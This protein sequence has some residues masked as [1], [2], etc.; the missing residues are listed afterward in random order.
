[1]KKSIFFLI[2]FFLV[3]PSVAKAADATI[4][5][6]SSSGVYQ[7]NKN[8]TT[9]I[10]INSGG[11]NVNAA[12]STLRF[13]PKYFNIV[14]INKDKSIFSLWTGNPKF[15][16]KTG[17]IN[18]GGGL[19]SKFHDRAG[20]ILTLTIKPIKAG[21]AKIDVGTTSQITLADGTGA[22]IY[23]PGLGSN[24][25]IGSAKDVKNANAF[26]AKNLG[27]FFLQTEVGNSLWFVNAG[28][29]R[30]YLIS[31]SSDLSTIARRIGVKTDHAL[32]VKALKSK[33]SKQSG[34]KFL[35]D[36]KDNKIYFI[37]PTTLKGQIITDFVA[38]YTS[39]VAAAKPIK[40]SDLY[41]I[42]DWAV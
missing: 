19:P 21:V 40:N 34:G 16:N 33:F 11:N 12:E 32:M 22:N 24:F 42:P 28:D 31:S 1:M 5:L 30:R 36:K 13:N 25:I 18:F 17:A 4:S 8:F 7:V 41:K 23:T 6:S 39:F 14:K 20:L 3:I 2:L 38:A 27:K 26:I 15:S 9:R 35:I 37:N 10:I 29:S